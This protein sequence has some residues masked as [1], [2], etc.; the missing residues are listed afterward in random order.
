[1]KTKDLFGVARKDHRQGDITNSLTES[2]IR[3]IQIRGGAAFRI[4]TN[5]IPIII[6]GTFRGWRKSK[7]PGAADIRA[8][9]NG[10]SVDI[11]VKSETDKLNDNQ[12]VFKQQVE[13]AKGQYWEVRSFTDF[14]N[15]YNYFIKNI[16][17]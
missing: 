12:K 3:F 9:V 15:Y 17:G 7:N 10:Y 1:M 5:G 13:E 14:F 16:S 6:N 11:E 4:N 8:I 2:I